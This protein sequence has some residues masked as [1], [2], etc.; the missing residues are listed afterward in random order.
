[1]RRSP[2]RSADGYLRPFSGLTSANLR[3]TDPGSL[4]SV[5]GRGGGRARDSRWSLVG[6]P[7][8][9][10]YRHRWLDRRDFLFHRAH[11]RSRGQQLGAVV[12]ALWIVLLVLGR[13]AV[14][15]YLPGTIARFGPR[16]TFLAV[17]VICA[18]LW[19]LTAVALGLG[20]ASVTVLYWFGPLFGALAVFA[21][22]LTTLYTEAYISG[23]EMAGALTRMDVVRGI[24]V[25][26]GAVLGGAL[27]LSVG[28]AWGLLARGLFEI[29]LIIMLMVARPA[30]EP[31]PPPSSR[32][33]W[34][35]LRADI[36]GNPLMR[37][38]LVLG[39]G[40][41]IFA[42]PFTELMVPIA[43]DLRAS[44]LVSGAAV[45]VASVAVGQSFAIWPV[46]W[47]SARVPQ[48]RSSIAMGATRGVGLA[49]Y[50]AASLIFTG[51]LELAV[52]AVIGLAFGM[53][54]SA[55]GALMVGAVVTTVTQENK[56]RAIVAFAF[57]CTLA[58]PLG[59]LLWGLI[60]D[61]ASVETALAVGALG[62]F[63]CTAWMWQR[64]RVA[65]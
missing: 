42:L 62:V 37:R 53:S 22:T 14:A 58:S 32:A 30:H 45:M 34:R 50:C 46:T 39:V 63:A 1:M 10:R 29:P 15:P 27:A 3:F 40:L 44:S 56:S 8:D 59:L 49:L 6:V 20:F 36:T 57:C 12:T 54:R 47:L 55:S 2:I 16:R 18:V 64:E 11:Q 26:V 33:V 24:S 51:S 25:A 28:A 4:Q 19:A 60:I 48:P 17:K 41:T 5:H 52:W 13:V 23:H 9:L 21:S 35:D 38:L 43:S 65:R 61:F 31:E 7:P